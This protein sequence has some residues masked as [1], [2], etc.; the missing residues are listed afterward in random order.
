[1]PRGRA[2]APSPSASRLA[3]T[4]TTAHFPPPVAYHMPTVY[5]RVQDLEEVQAPQQ[6]QC[7]RW[8]RPYP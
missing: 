4:P 3:S 2:C 1:M 5:H 8:V 6:S 7:W